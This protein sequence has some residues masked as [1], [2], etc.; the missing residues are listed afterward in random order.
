MAETASDLIAEWER[1]ETDRVV[2]LTHWQDRF[3]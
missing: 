3:T 2:W 1:R